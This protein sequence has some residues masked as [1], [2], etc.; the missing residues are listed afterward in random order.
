MEDKPLL[1]NSDNAKRPWILYIIIGILLIVIIILIIVIATKK[2]DECK[3]P[4]CKSPD[5]SSPYD[6]F[7]QKILMVQ[8]PYKEN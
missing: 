6:V 2:C 1:D 3:C 7:I 5:E 8:L 4:E